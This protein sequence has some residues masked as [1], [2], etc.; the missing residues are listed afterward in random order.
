MSHEIRTP[1]TAIIGFA[2]LLCRARR[3]RP[4]EERCVSIQEGGQRL[5]ET[6]NAILT[7]ARLESGKMDLVLEE[8][9]SVKEAAGHGSTCSSTIAGG[10]GLSLLVE[11][12]GQSR[13]AATIDRGALD[14]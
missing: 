5:L 4:D 12:T 8:G 9:I 11:C 1:L 3:R 2:S 7:L 13:F 14:L 6:L 10:K